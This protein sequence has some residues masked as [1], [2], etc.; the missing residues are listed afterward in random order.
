MAE[1]L[2]VA[3]SLLPVR[4]ALRQNGI[5]VASHYQRDKQGEQLIAALA[6]CGLGSGGEP[7]PAPAAAVTAPAAASDLDQLLVQLRSAAERLQR[8]GDAAR[9]ARALAAASCLMPDDLPL[10]RA[11]AKAHLDSGAT[12]CALR[13]YDE[14]ARRAVATTCAS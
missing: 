10:L 13:L 1:A 9:A 7:A 11:A 8:A 14:L 4:D 6:R 3:G 5:A 12:D 2:V